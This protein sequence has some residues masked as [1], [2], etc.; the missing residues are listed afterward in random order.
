MCKHPS[1]RRYQL[2]CRCLGCKAVKAKYKREW[3][4]ANKRRHYDTVW[5]AA[6]KRLYGI[7]PEDYKDMLR[8]QRGRCVICKR[9]P[10]KNRLCVDHCHTTGVIRGLLCM[11]CNRMLGRLGDDV[12]AFK[13]AVKHLET[14]WVFDKE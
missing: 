5:K 10:K 3:Y 8:Q 12:T 14:E 9:L 11:G 6:I 2:G 4:R 7:T 13:R 1:H